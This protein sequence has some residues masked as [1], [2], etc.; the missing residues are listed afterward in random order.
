MTR[1]QTPPSSESYQPVSRGLRKHLA[2][3]PGNA[4]KLYVELLLAADFA[5]PHKGQ[6]AATFAE[7]ATRLKMHRI[8]VFKAAKKLEPRYITW[9]RA[10]N[11]FDTTIFTVQKYKSVKDFACSRG[12]TG[13]VQ[14]RYKRANSAACKSF[15]RQ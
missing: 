14:A 9:D 4:V 5:G 1:S 15:S 11:Q 6:V 12:T 10:K 8:T 3:L 2:A 13:E 7:L